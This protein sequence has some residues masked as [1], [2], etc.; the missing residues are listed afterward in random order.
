LRHSSVNPLERFRIAWKQSRSS[1]FA[2]PHFRA[3]NRLP[4]GLKSG[5]GFFLKC[6]GRRKSAGSCA[7]RPPK[8][9]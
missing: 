7:S 3:E 5:A 1:I 4:P 9:P 6:S 2:L 8:V